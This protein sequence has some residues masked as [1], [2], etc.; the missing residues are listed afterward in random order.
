MIGIASS[1]R[2]K[3]AAKWKLKTWLSEGAV[4]FMVNWGKKLARDSWDRQENWE[5]SVQAEVADVSQ[6]VETPIGR[7]GEE[8]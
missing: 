4:M 6:L 2:E 1:L 7:E 3:S 8:V 5:G